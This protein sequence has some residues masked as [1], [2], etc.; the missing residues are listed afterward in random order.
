MVVNV[1][2]G[3]NWSTQRKP[4]TC[5]KL[6]HIML[7][8]VHLTWAGFEL[9]TLVVIDTDCIGSYKS[10]H[11]TM[12]TTTAPG[13]VQHAHIKYI[14]CNLQLIWNFFLIKCLTSLPYQNQLFWHSVYHLAVSFQ[15]S[16]LCVQPYVYDN[17]LLLILSAGRIFWLLV[18]LTIVIRYLLIQEFYNALFWL[19]LVLHILLLLYII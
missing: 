3:G 18:P 9:T 5:R 10:N 6:Y 13:T 19:L 4:L 12:M 7:Y 17:I 1:I 16:D 2:G 15:V 11:H 14:Q 8:R